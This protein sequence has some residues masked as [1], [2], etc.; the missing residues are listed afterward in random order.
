M[1]FINDFFFILH[2]DQC[3]GHYLRSKRYFGNV[4][5]KV[6]L[7]LGLLSYLERH[8]LKTKKDRIFNIYDQ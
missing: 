5:A 8:D 4:K 7:H 3:Q 2:I 1:S 6:S